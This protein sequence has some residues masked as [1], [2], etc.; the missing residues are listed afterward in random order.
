MHVVPKNN[1]R[2]GMSSRLPGNSEKNASKLLVNIKQIF[3]RYYIPS[4]MVIA[5]SNIKFE[6]SF[7]ISRLFVVIFRY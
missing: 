4:D 7:L 1:N 6:K 2:E 5:D 3:Q